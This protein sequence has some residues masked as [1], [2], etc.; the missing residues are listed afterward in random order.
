MFILVLAMGR[1]MML[2]R[3]MLVFV[4][5]AL[6]AVVVRYRLYS[7]Q[8]F[9]FAVVGKNVCCI[10]IFLVMML[11]FVRVVLLIFM[12]VF[13]VLVPS[14]MNIVAWNMKL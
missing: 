11:V 2:G 8:D 5:M 9:M 6:L 10:G 1:I 13:V 4:M 7:H 12:A 3:R 14:S